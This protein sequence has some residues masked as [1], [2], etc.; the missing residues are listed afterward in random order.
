[1][2]RVMITCR[3]TGKSLFT[4]LDLASKEAL[5]RSTFDRLSVRCPH[6]GYAHIWTKKDAWVEGLLDGLY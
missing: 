3:E 5:E 2:A 6:C 4:G 1:M